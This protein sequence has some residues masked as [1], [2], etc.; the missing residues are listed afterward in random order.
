MRSCSFQLNGKVKAG[1]ETDGQVTLDGGALPLND[2]N[3]WRLSSPT[4][5]EFVGT[6][7]DKV[8]D[9]N[10]HKVTAKFP[11]GSIIPFDPPA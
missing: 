1:S 7:C 2:P 8:K 10:D 4:T 6:S 11:C 9:K 5:V 3:G